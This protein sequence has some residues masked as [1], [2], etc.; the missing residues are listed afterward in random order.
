MYKIDVEIRPANCRVRP[1]VKDEE[2]ERKKKMEDGQDVSAAS[3]S[4]AVCVCLP[5]ITENWQVKNEERPRARIRW[6]VLLG[7]PFSSGI[8]DGHVHHLHVHFLLSLLWTWICMH[9]NQSSSQFGKQFV[10]YLC[11]YFFFTASGM[12]MICANGPP[13]VFFLATWNSME[14]TVWRYPPKFRRSQIIF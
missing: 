14:K 11:I 4:R 1:L 5:P 7:H 12:L 13:D 3:V 6:D 9:N 8:L 10:F 2:G